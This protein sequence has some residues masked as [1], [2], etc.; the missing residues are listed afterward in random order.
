MPKSP[1]RLRNE[2]DDRSELRQ[3]S[4]RITNLVANTELC[5]TNLDWSGIKTPCGFQGETHL[6]R[7]ETIFNAEG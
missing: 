4:M 7:F 1:L 3:S 6:D 5:L 2:I